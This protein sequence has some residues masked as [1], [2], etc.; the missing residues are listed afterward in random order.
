MAAASYFLTFTS[1]RGGWGRLRHIDRIGGGKAVLETFFER[2]LELAFAR[3]LPLAL[4]L[5]VAL[6]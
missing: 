2:P 1:Y 5:V 4:A 6:L 3:G